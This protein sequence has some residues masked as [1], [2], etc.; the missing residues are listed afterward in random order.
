M[1]ASL[2]S[3][4]ATMSL[5]ASSLNPDDA[6]K[7][8]TRHRCHCTSD[9]FEPMQLPQRWRI[10]QAWVVD[11]SRTGFAVNACGISDCSFCATS[12]DRR[13]AIHSFDVSYR[14]DFVYSLNHS[15]SVDLLCLV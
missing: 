14:V 10:R 11:A 9:K 12:H 13:N 4:K 8:F 1:T 2:S 3:A 15:R 5:T 6:G 7:Y